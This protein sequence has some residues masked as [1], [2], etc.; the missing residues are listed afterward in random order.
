VSAVIVDLKT[1][2]VRKIE[3]QEPETRE[4]A[5][6]APKLAEIIENLEEIL[7]EARDGT[8]D[9]IAIAYVRPVGAACG[10]FSTKGDNIAGLLGSMAILQAKIT[11]VL[12]P[13]QDDE[14]PPPDSA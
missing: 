14:E 4:R 3:I 2:N 6:L 13:P 1:R 11:T 10:F 8:V 9:S 12:D 5:T 7:Q